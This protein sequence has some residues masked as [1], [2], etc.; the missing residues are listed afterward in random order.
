MRLPVQFVFGAVVTALFVTVALLSFV[1]VPHDVAA[2]SIAD[3]LKAPSPDFWLGTDH[4]GRD[5][6]SMLMVGARTS[7]AVA[8]VA[9]G[10][11][12]IV[13]VPLGLAAAATRGS[14]VDEVIMR[15]N[16]LI[17]AF[18]SLV[19]AILITAVF[20]PS[21]TNAIIAI[22][23]FN[24]PVFARVARGGA[25][26]SFDLTGL[27][28]R[29]R[30]FIAETMGEGEV[31]IKV[32]GKPALKIQESWFAGVW[33]VAGHGVDRIDVGQVPPVAL[34]RAHLPHRAG[35]GSSIKAHDGL[36]NGP[37]ILTELMDKTASWQRGD[38]PHVVNLTLL[39]HTESD[40]VWLARAFGEGSVAGAVLQ[41]NRSAHS[42]YFRGDPC[43]RS[44][45]RG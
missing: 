6:L 24:I 33:L 36:A 45:A 19:I 18:P 25:A 27:D 37:A 35:E 9:V 17:F 39:P 3:K 13:G 11:G 34:E 44:G 29:N 42:R 41:F 31:S 1:W 22:G 15:G 2:L 12:I 5:T 38:A 23:I 43:A 16:D 4:L 26:E 20:G 8:V 7:I 14:L 32:Q 21:A 10:I 30:A 28:A 40:L